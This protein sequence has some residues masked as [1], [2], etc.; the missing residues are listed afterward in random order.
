MSPQDALEQLTALKNLDRAASLRKHH[1]IDRPYLGLTN[2]QL[3]D[4]AKDWRQSL[5]LETRLDLAA[6]LWLSNIFEARIVAAKLLTQ[7]RITPDDATWQLITSW[8]PQF[9]TA[10]IADQVCMAGMK[11]LTADPTRLD[12]VESWT[13][14]EDLWT[15]R[16]ALVI[17]QPW[18]KQN[19][20]KPDEL[21]TRERI[22]GWIASYAPDHQRLLQNAIATWL[23][24]LSK[25]DA[26]RVRAFLEEH[27]ETLKPYARRDAARLLPATS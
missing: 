25:H 17:T 11:R 1:K 8:V 4:L 5:D 15:R 10:A 14:S 22:L 7:A 13:T 24:D 6:Q 27:G 3:G 16:A 23:C 19:N 18:T 20:P 21:A 26:P 9:D 2:E 12:E